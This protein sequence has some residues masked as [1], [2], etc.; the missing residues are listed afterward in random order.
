MNIYRL[1]NHPIEGPWID[2]SVM[3][4]VLL[5]SVFIGLYAA[6]RVSSS[7]HAPLM[8]LTNALSSVIIVVAFM[9]AIDSIS[10]A[11]IFLLGINI[12]GGFLITYRMLSMFFGKGKKK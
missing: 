2:I 11:T 3:I 4:V 5:L 10:I 8:S 6:S 1:L 9:G 7:L 12:F